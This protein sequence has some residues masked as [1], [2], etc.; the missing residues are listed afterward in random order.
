M[1]SLFALLAGAFVLGFLIFAGWRGSQIYGDLDPGSQRDF[2]IGF[3]GVIILNVIL[4]P[5]SLVLRG[6]STLQET[7]ATMALALPWVVNLVL[8]LFFAFYRRWIALGALVLVGFLLALVVLAR[9]LFLPWGVDSPQLTEEMGY[10]LVIL[11]VV[12]LAGLAVLLISAV[13]LG[14]PVLLLRFWR[15]VLA[16]SGPSDQKY[17]FIGFFGIISLNVFL[18]PTSLFLIEKLIRS[19][20]ID[21]FEGAIFA[22]KDAFLTRRQAF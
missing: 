1:E 20:T 13:V 14:P 9:V 21:Y 7:R 15:K 18:Y 8:L 6:D 5:L 10:R 4:Y 12:L 22:L 16:D 3:F 19:R 11:F 17:F 2:L